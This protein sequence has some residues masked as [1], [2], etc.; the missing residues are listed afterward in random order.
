MSTTTFAV[1]GIDG[2]EAGEA[3]IPDFLTVADVTP[4]LATRVGLPP[5]PDVANRYSLWYSPPMAEEQIT[6]PDRTADQPAGTQ[7]FLL[8]RD[9]QKLSDLPEGGSLRVAFQP[10]PAG[11][12]N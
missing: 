1:L 3:E 2:R 11:P 10:R 7:P 9:D 12:K 6:G 8:L 5:E 4:E